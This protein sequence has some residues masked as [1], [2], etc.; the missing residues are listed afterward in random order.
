MAALARAN[1]A[2][3]RRVTQQLSNELGL[4]SSR[5]GPSFWNSESEEGKLRLHFEKIRGQRKDLDKETRGNSSLGHS[6]ADA[7][8]GTG[9]PRIRVAPAAFVIASGA[10]ARW[11]EKTGGGT[12]LGR[13]REKYN[14]LACRMTLNPCT[15]AL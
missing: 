7:I 14:C 3:V 1:F 4:S 10:A 15:P 13:R 9:R 6:P 5:V 2:D 8:R 12:M 11:V